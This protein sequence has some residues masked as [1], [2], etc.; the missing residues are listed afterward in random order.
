MRR[1]VALVS[2]ILLAGL[3]SAQTTSIDKARTLMNEKNYQ[4]ARAELGKIVANEPANGPALLELARCT[5]ALGDFDASIAA[6]RKAL[7]IP[8]QPR[9]SHLEIAMSLAVRGDADAA[10]AEIEQIVAMG[11]NKGL[12]DR[13]V[14]APELASLRKHPKFEAVVAK[15]LPCGTPEYRQ[16]DFW[17]GSWEVRDP[18]GHVVGHNDVTLHLDGCMLMENWKS[19]AGH[20]GMSMNYF[21]PTDGSWNQIFIDNGGVPSGWPPLKGKLVDGKMVLSTLQGVK[22]ETRWIWSKTG[23][24]RVR[25][26][27]EQLGDDGKT[28]SVIWDSYYGKAK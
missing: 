23:D 11:A 13:V 12:H 27:A 25:Q 24:G 18:A 8:F 14:S 16:F 9:I 3:A 20:A 6:A 5:R 22:P 7:A 17:L 21:E 15:L 26:L 1:L 28:W 10:I 19:G 4:A 2:S